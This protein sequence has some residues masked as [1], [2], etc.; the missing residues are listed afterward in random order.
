MALLDM[1]DKITKA[2]D[3]NEFSVGIFIDLAKA[4]DTV[5]HTILLKKCLTMV[6]EVYNFSGLAVILLIAH[7]EFLVMGPSLM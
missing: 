7:K 3:N 5:D 2:I 4:F 6:S 1:E